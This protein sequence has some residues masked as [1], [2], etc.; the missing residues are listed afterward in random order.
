MAYEA[1][2]QED[3]SIWTYAFFKNS[4]N[5]SDR[6][7]EFISQIFWEGGFGFGELVAPEI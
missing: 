1:F 6:L 7:L 5:R 4:N 2:A 3:D